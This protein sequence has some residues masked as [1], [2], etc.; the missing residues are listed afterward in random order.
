MSNISKT[1]I[2]ISVVIP[3]VLLLIL[4]RICGINFETNDDTGIM[5]FVTGA[6]TGSPTAETVFCNILW[7]GFV[8][9]LYRI[10][11]SIPWYICIYMILMWLSFSILCLSC[12]KIAAEVQECD[13]SKKDIFISRIMGISFF[14][15]L[16][17]SVFSFYSVLLQFTAIPALC[18]MGA[19]LLMILFPKG[20]NYCYF[21]FSILLFFADVI[22]PKV[23]YMATLA[24]VLT[25][26][27]MYFMYRI[28]DK[29]YVLSAIIIQAGTYIINA[30]Y[31]Q[32]N[33]WGTFRAFHRA[34]AYWKDYTHPSFADNPNLYESVGWTEQLYKLA[35]KWFFLDKRVTTDA[36]ENLNEKIDVT[37]YFSF[38]ELTS[39]L[40]SSRLRMTFVLICFFVIMASII[41]VKQR[42]YRNLLVIWG[43]GYW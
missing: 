3:L 12:I 14:L 38:D 24:F 8:S 21:A 10:N 41:F 9:V 36:F 19:I 5:M 13:S 16:F 29:I 23:G 39:V 27:A 42:K 7:G 26:I 20:N 17:F 43:G 22:R 28:W 11:E 37:S 33:G 30:L 32:Y 4:W 2:I 31:E 15:I 34:R 35:D 25:A 6:K 40:L 18:G 1:D